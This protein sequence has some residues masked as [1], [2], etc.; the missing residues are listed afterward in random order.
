MSRHRFMIIFVLAA[1]LLGSAG[2][3]PAQPPPAKAEMRSTPP[4]WDAPRHAVA[5]IDAAGLEHQPLDMIDNQR[6]L[7]L[8][9]TIDG[10]P[11]TI[12]AFVG[13]DRLRALQGSAHT[14]DESGQVW[15]E[16][17]EANTV[18][19][20]QFFTLWGVRF[21]AECLGAAC[22]GVTVTADGAPVADPIG[23][24]MASSSEIRVA[25]T[26]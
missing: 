2:C 9:V 24:V 4:P 25:G 20:G 6:L 26:S 19:L 14:H 17:T 23:L 8:E 12:P 3:A 11:V 10:V 22:G 18:T 7:Q 21:D 5:N 16:G 15:L 1:L 13:I